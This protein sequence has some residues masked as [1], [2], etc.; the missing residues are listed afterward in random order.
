MEISSVS[1]QAIASGSDQNS[2]T[3]IRVLKKAMDIQ[4]QTATQLI[5]SI[6]KPA[7]VSDGVKGSNIDVMA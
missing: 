1:P 5:E 3:G 6:P 7:P 2:Q 4:Q